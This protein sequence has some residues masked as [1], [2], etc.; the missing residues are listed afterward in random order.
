MTNANEIRELTMDD[1]GAV[2]SDTELDGVS[3]GGWTKGG[4]ADVL[5][6]QVVATP[7]STDGCIQPKAGAGQ[8]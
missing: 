2:L 4:G 7:K 1:L 6:L 3:G 8:S 5:R